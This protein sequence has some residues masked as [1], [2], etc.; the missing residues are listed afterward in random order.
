M[1]GSKSYFVFSLCSSN[2]HVCVCVRVRNTHTHQRLFVCRARAVAQ[3]KPSPYERLG[4]KKDKQL[5]ANTCPHACAM[6]GGC[7]CVCVRVCVCGYERKQTTQAHLPSNRERRPANESKFRQRGGGRAGDLKTVKRKPT[8]AF[9]ISHF[10][11]CVPTNTQP[12]THTHT[13]THAET[14]I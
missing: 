6:K 13:R 11:L 7:V 5:P 1:S 3:E 14:H 4:I 9:W 8:C 10:S 2:V 12:H